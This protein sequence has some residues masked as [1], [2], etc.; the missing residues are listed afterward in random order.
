MAA[1]LEGRT[2]AGAATDVRFLHSDFT[3]PM[4]LPEAGFDLLVSLFAGLVWDACQQ[5]L[6]PDGL[7]LANTSHGDASVAALDPRLRLVAAVHH[8]EQRY[9]L[10]REDLSAYL[11]AKKPAA[12]DAELIR[13]SGRGIAYTR[14][15]FAYVFRR[16]AA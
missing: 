12:A 14:S 11:I 7:L 3:T 13:A 6:A 10:D 2:R 5:Y 1:E 8:R 15:A 4:P 16:V 9:R